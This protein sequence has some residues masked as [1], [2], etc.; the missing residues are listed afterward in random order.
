[1]LKLKRNTIFSG[2][3]LYSSSPHRPKPTSHHRPRHRNQATAAWRP[4]WRNNHHPATRLP[5]RPRSRGAGPFAHFGSQAT[6]SVGFHRPKHNFLPPHL[7]VSSPW[8]PWW[9]WRSGGRGKGER[10]STRNQEQR[11]RSRKSRRCLWRH[12]E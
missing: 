2:Q 10:V 9:R 1:M 3:F 11:V 8:Q 12:K 6:S 5:W 7:A 4:L